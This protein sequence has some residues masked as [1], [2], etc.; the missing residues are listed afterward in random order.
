MYVWNC[1]EVE[2]MRVITIATAS[3]PENVEHGAAANWF[4]CVHL[5]DVYIILLRST[6]SLLQLFYAGRSKNLSTLV[7][8][9]PVGVA[10]Q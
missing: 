1:L 4:I 8:Y 9:W 6:L 5:L 7:Q 3:G 10:T 2:L